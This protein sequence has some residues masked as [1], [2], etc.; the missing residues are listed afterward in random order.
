MKKTG[1]LIFAALLAVSATFA[2]LPDKAE[3]ISPLLYGEKIPNADLV[4]A[5]GS[6]HQL[7]SLIQ[8]K[9]SVLLFYRGGW[10]PYCNR[11]LAEIRD[12]EQQV[13]ELGYQILAV[14][15]DSPENLKVTDKDQQLN[16]RLFSDANGELCKKAGIAFK[17]PDKYGSMLKEKSGGQNDEGL[18]PVPAVFVVDHDGVILFEYINPDYSTRLSGGLLL[19][20]LNQFSSEN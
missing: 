4:E 12:V 13:E 19:A 8:E 15:P 5:D 16:Y 20:V 2:Q 18:L 11:H 3:D 14:S 6:S 7:Y 1:L 17:A 10:C 9:P